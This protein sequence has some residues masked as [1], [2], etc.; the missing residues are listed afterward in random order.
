MDGWIDGWS[1]GRL[2]WPS[3]QSLNPAKNKR[4]K[5]IKCNCILGDCLLLLLP[6]LLLLLWHLLF[7]CVVII[8]VCCLCL[9]PSPITITHYIFSAFFLLIFYRCWY[10]CCCCRRRV[11]RN[12]YL[13]LNM[14]HI[15][16]SLNCC[17]TLTIYFVVYFLFVDAA[18]LTYSYRNCLVRAIG[19]CE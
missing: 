3:R 6:L 12:T 10:R 11:R 19:F 16:H 14:H 5:S 9:S 15:L 18:V 17:C 4:N 2:G 7:E 8:V 13:K 1:V